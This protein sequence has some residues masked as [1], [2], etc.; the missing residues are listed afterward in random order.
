MLFVPGSSTFVALAYLAFEWSRQ[1]SSPQWLQ[2]NLVLLWAVRLGLY[3]FV[4]VLKEGGDRRFNK[5]RDNPA[6]LFAFWTMQG[7]SLWLC[8]V[9]LCGHAMSVSVAMQGQ[10]LWLCKVSLWLCKVSVCGY[11]RSVSVA[12][13]G[14]SLWLSKVSLCCYPRSVSVAI[15]GQSLWLSKVSLCGY[16]LWCGVLLSLILFCRRASV[17]DTRTVLQLLT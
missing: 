10:S 1:Q 8:G 6:T 5:A 3:L 9:S 12:M 11:A 16:A 7:Q 4:R 2:R 17:L 13:Q 15:Q 14:Q